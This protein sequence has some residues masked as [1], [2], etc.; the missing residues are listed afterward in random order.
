VISE[1]SPLWQ[2]MPKG[3]RSDEKRRREVVRCHIQGE[4][5]VYVDIETV[6]MH[7]YFFTSH[8]LV[9]V[10][11]IWNWLDLLTLCL[12]SVDNYL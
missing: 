7:I 6:H 3:E 5:L 9:Y 4:L 10:L 2:L 11:C 1:A 12:M 8:A